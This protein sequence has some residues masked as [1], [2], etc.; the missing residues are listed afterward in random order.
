MTKLSKTFGAHKHTHETMKFE[1]GLK[2]ITFLCSTQLA[3]SYKIIL[4]V[5]VKMP[6]NVGILTID[7]RINTIFQ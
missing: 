7:S 2:V 5:N 3:V 1:Q 6:T 4:L